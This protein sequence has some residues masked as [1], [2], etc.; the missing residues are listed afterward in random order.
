MFTSWKTSLGG[1]LTALGA[2]LLGANALGWM[3]PQWQARFMLAGWLLTILGPAI[4]GVF[5]RDNNV[6]SE[7]VK[8]N[9]LGGGIAAAVLAGLLLIGATGCANVHSTTK[10]T[11][12][13]PATGITVTE[14][15]DARLNT[16]FD[17]NSAVTKFKNSPA[18]VVSSNGF[19]MPAG[20]SIGSLSETSQAPSVNLGEI[21]GQAMRTYTGKP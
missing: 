5:A 15:S 9:M 7:D 19:V 21:L 11:T 4:T 17:G 8:R 14:E 13:D 3:P 10:K 1:I 16:F 12:F 6:T 18:S 20:T 2:G